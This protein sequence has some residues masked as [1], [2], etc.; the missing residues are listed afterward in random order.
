LNDLQKGKRVSACQKLL[1]EFQEQGD[2]FFDGF[3]TVDEKWITYQNPVTQKYW[4][5]PDQPEV[6]QQPVREIHCSKRLIT[7]FWDKDGPIYRS[8]LP[9]NKTINANVYC[10]MLD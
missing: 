9:P 6:V 2:Q 10:K 4:Y 5:H 3:I 7:V 8:I 1:K